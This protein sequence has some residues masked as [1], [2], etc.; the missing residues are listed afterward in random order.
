MSAARMRPDFALTGRLSGR[1]SPGRM[2]PV[3]SIVRRSHQF[4]APQAP[5]PTGEGETCLKVRAIAVPYV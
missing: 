2:P 4:A 5:R 3:T 1:A